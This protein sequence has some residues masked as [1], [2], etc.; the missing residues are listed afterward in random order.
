MNFLAGSG[1]PWRV[2]QRKRG[3]VMAGFGGEN[4]NLSR[5]AFLVIFQ[6]IVVELFVHGGLS[7]FTGQKGTYQ[8]QIFNRCGWGPF[9]KKKGAG[10][11]FD[12]GF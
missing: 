8:G 1:H 6:R 3:L 10:A 7:L 4:L 5:R 9:L 11:F 2:G 12:R